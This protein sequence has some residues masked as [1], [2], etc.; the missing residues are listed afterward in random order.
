MFPTPGHTVGHQSVVVETANETYV[1]AGDAAPSFDNLDGDP[2]Q[3]LPFMP[4]GI[5][6]NLDDAWESLEKITEIATFVLPS[7]DPR[8][9]EKKKY[10]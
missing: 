1:I 5:Y 4:S 9:L 2:E 3:M 7:H 6:V 10:K 8:V